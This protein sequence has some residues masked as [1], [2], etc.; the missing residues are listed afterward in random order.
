MKFICKYYEPTLQILTYNNFVCPV[1]VLTN[2]NKNL[3][4][5]PEPYFFTRHAIYNNISHKIFADL[6]LYTMDINFIL[7]VRAVINANTTKFTIKYGYY[8]KCLH[9]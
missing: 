1:S 3:G 9:Q 6:C 2:C 7:Q 5:L 8:S 4:V